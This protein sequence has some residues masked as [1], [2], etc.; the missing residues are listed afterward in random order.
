MHKIIKKLHKTLFSLA[1]TSFAISIFSFSAGANVIAERDLLVNSALAGVDQNFLGKKFSTAAILSN[2]GLGVF[3]GLDY[4]KENMSSLGFHFYSN[5][6]IDGPTTDNYKMNLDT[7][8][9]FKLINNFYLG[10]GIGFIVDNTH[11]ILCTTNNFHGVAPKKTSYLRGGKYNIFLCNQIS[12]GKDRNFIVELSYYGVSTPI[13]AYYSF[14]LLNLNIGWDFKIAEFNLNTRFS[15]F[16]NFVNIKEVQVPAFTIS[17]N[18]DTSWAFL[19]F[20][21]KTNL[22]FDPKNMMGFVQA[23]VKL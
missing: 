17:A 20:G 10:G 14:K 22:N 5:R 7:S 2:Q 21:A 23:T 18:T 13:Y 15:N 16:I 11:E 4:L 1:C 19:S 3:A 8:I 6:I 9:K 12:I